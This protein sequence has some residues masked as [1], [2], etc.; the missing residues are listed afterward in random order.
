M[1]GPSKKADVPAADSEREWLIDESTRID[2]LSLPIPAPFPTKPKSSRK[3][4]PGDKRA[5]A[6][7]TPQKTQGSMGWQQTPSSP[8]RS[9]KGRSWVKLAAPLAGMLVISYL[10]YRVATRIRTPTSET[11]VADHR[12]EKFDRDTKSATLSQPLQ[13]PVSSA[14]SPSLT[15]TP[16]V[17]LA[18]GNPG[19]NI[20]NTLV[21]NN[22][23]NRELAFEIAA[24]DME[25]REG[26]LVAV[27]AG[28]LPASVAAT[29][30]FSNR[31]MNVKPWLNASVKVS[32]TIPSPSPV[33]AVLI[34]MSGKDSIP[35]S[36]GIALQAILGT[37]ITF[38][39]PKIYGQN[40][41]NPGALPQGPVTNYTV[42]QWHAH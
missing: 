33:L 20:S 39:D 18:Q 5:P 36:P 30:L 10:A 24:E 23:S 38:V 2:Y 25:V 40:A 37:L 9:R 29:V 22:Q 41:A 6:K 19:Q 13:S 12:G 26:R 32:L 11:G 17:I 28:E 34:V 31:T 35:T 3:A 27:R 7:S 16:A 1:A 42:S 8:P 21:I 4:E 15:L 14:E